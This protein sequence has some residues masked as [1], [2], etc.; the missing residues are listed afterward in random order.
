[1]PKPPNS[2]DRRRLGS[3]LADMS[4]FGVLSV[5]FEFLD[6]TVQMVTGGGKDEQRR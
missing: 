2:I 5:F 1:M 6:M 3:E 4:W